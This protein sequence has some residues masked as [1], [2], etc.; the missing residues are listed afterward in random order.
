MTKRRKIGLLILGS[1]YSIGLIWGQFRLPFAAVKNL[2]DYPMLRMPTPVSA[3]DN[4]LIMHDFQKMYLKQSM[5]MTEG[6][7]PP[8]ISVDVTWNVGI[9]ARVRSG[10]YSSPTGAESL[11]CLYICFFGGWIP[12]YTF[13]ESMA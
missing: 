6:T 7:Q 11:D 3:S 8:R 10:H 12:I 1:L 9:L 5:N 2:R 4:K 13:S